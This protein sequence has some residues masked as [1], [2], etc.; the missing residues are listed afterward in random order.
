MCDT[1]ER[2]MSFDELSHFAIFSGP[3][4]EARPRKGEGEA[5]T[6]CF[7]RRAHLRLF[8]NS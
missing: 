1:V 3:K 8:L 7:L 4:V 5:T 2:V 6:I